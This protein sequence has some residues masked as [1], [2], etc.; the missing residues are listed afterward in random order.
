MTEEDKTRKI[1]ELEE[2]GVIPYASKYNKEIKA[3]DVKKLELGT[4]GIQ[5]AGRII[6][7]RK[8]G[9]LT[10]ADLMD[11][12]GTIQLAFSINDFGKERYEEFKEMISMGDFIGVKGELF[13]T[14]KGE[15]TI[16]VKDFQLLSKCM[17]NLPDK[18][19]GVK[20]EKIKLSERY[21]DLLANE[22]TRQRF[23]Q[24]NRIIKFIRNY[25]EENDFIEVETPILQPQLSGANARPFTTYYHALKKEVVLRIAPETYLKRL[26]VGGFERVFEIGRCFRNEDM[27]RS[28]LQDFT[29]LEYYAS[30]WDYKDNM[31]FVENMIKGLLKKVLGSLQ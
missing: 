12:T 7:M 17:Q 22:E 30:Y 11:Y 1:K 21:L 26:L 5:T 9:K 19:H 18:W 13:K 6:Q 14:R 20:D 3:R 16:K 25:L 15:I 8:F 4:K 31:K 24:R 27:D 23:L 28:H 10:F 2:K 29:M